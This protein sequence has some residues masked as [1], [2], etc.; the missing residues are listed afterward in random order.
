MDTKALIAELDA[1]I[2]RLQE[3]KAL[4][5][6]QTTSPRRGRPP[7]KNPKPAVFGRRSMS[8]EVR[9]R[10]VAAQKARW[11]KTRKKKA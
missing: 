4:L 10:I 6:G 1:E 5:T 2:E 11:A 9:A 3:V 7:G 8:P